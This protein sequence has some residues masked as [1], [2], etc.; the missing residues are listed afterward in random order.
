MDIP[1][2]WHLRV[3]A[4]MGEMEEAVPAAPTVMA[5]MAVAEGWV[6]PVAM[7]EMEA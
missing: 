3:M 2:G 4:A 6:A 1:E 5:V 7:E